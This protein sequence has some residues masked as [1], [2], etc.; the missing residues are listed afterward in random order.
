MAGS[1]LIVTEDEKLLDDLLRLCAAAGAEAEVAHGAPPGPGVWEGAPLVLVGDDRAG[2]LSRS[3]RVSVRRA[4]VLLVSRDMDDPGVWQRGMG[5]GAEHVVLLPD[6]E[7]WLTGRIA[8]AAEGVGR[9]ALTVGVL[10]GCGGAGASTLACALAV[11]AARAGHRTMLVDADPLGG[12]LD[13]PL[14]GERAEGLRWPALAESRGRVGGVALEESLPVLH[15][16]RVLSWDRGDSVA[17]PSEAVRAV[18]GAARRRGGV[19]VV[20]LPRWLD[21]SVAEAL[22]QLDLGL[23]VVPAEL[24]AVAAA[25]RVASRTGMVLRDLRTVVRGCTGSGLAG[26]EIARL[27][28]LRLAGEVP[29]EAGLSAAVDAGRPPGTD[30]RSPLAQ[31]CAG[32]WARAMP[33]GGGAPP[34]GGPGSVA[35]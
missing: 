19:V 24:R 4:G 9:Q 17:V 5:I 28:G 33:E 23:L 18:L 27:L 15:G 20:D 1:I 14:G 8:D 32:F 22:S 3:A 25:H 21:E 26:G 35:A 6:G 34:V 2:P 29:T 7:P 12:G 31:F 30:A 10:G 13:V 11:T 16:L